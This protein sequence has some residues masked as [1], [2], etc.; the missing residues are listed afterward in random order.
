MCVRTAETGRADA[1]ETSQVLWSRVDV[2]GRQVGIY[3]WR[4]RR[5]W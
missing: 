3:A 1:E 5:V 2:D 4:R